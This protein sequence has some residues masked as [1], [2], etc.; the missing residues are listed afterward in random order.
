M[1]LTRADMEAI[2]RRN[3]SVIYD[4]RVIT[5]I[6]ELPNDAELAKGDAVKEAE[7]RASLRAQSDA[8]AAQ[9][10]TLDEN[11][12]ASDSAVAAAEKKD[13]AAEK[14]DAAEAASAAKASHAED[15]KATEDKKAAEASHAEAAKATKKSEGK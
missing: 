2:V 1:A 4:G 6:G 14:K 7:A 5:S 15:K 3:E 10:K 9:L 13:A 8:I 11:K 12:E